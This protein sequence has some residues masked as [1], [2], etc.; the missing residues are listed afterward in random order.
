MWV[1]CKQMPMDQA[2]EAFV[3]WDCG[4]RVRRADLRKASH[5]W[6][7]PTKLGT[8]SRAA[9]K[10]AQA[11]TDCNGA[12]VLDLI[13]LEK[14]RSS[15]CETQP[16][17]CWVICDSVPVC[18]AVDLLCPCTSAELLAF[19]GRS[20][21]L[22]TDT[23]IQQ[24]FIENVLHS[25][26]RLSISHGLPLKARTRTS[27]APKGPSQHKQRKP[28]SEKRIRRTKQQKSYGHRCL[29]LIRRMRV[30]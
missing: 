14:D 15:L 30:H 23:Q 17:T 20:S 16:R 29:Q 26:L 18:V 4:E 19:H 24:G 3:R 27:G 7:D 2:R 1:H 11:N 12:L 21:P 6:L 9:E 28:K 22:A 5:L 25:I 10:H 13:G 8:L